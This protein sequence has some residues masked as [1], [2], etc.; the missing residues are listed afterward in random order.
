M[1][2]LFLRPKAYLYSFRWIICLFDFGIRFCFFFQIEDHQICVCVR[3]RPL[4]KKGK[5]DDEL[6]ALF[7]AFK[8]H[9]CSVLTTQSF[10]FSCNYK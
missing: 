7:S 5:I 8:Q 1:A 2:V 4:N 9:K 6:R 3:K 10:V